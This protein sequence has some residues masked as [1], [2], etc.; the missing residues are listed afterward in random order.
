MSYL[1]S[2]RFD[3]RDSADLA[4]MRLRRG[5]VRFERVGL[6]SRGGERRVNAGV[7]SPY[8]INMLNQPGASDPFFPPVGS[9]A[10]FPGGT[11]PAGEVILKLRV[12]REDLSRA[13]DAVR[14]AGGRHV[15][16]I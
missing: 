15:D 9:R 16:V 14:S 10:V 2:A 12:S 5:G 4:L 6:L 11:L 1:M 13:R 8:S 7:F 3:D